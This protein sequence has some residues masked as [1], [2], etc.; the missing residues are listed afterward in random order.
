M[1]ST[2][3][4][5]MAASD[6][7]VPEWSHLCQVCLTFYPEGAQWAEPEP[8][9]VSEGFLGSTAGDDAGSTGSSTM[10]Q[11]VTASD[12]HACHACCAQ[13]LFHVELERVESS[14]SWCVTE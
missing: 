9:L 4:V 1:T 11:C 10:Q 13:I 7:A 3:V 6:C 5:L 12:S 8:V 2:A 14:P